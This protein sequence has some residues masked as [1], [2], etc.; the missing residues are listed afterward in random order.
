[1]K[2][3]DPEKLCIDGGSA[4]GYTTLACL[5][6]RNE[7]FKAGSS[8]F[9][10]SDVEDLVKDIHKFESRYIECKELYRERSPI[11]HVDKVNCPMTF[12]QGD[13]VR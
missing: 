6:Q 7:V 8:M 2:A 5:I 9:G 13:E 10:M 11:Y 1:M 3:I 12:L 4:C